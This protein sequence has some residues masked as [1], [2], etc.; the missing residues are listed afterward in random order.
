MVM[1]QGGLYMDWDF[2]FHEAGMDNDDMTDALFPSFRA[3]KHIVLNPP[4]HPPKLKHQPPFPPL[5]ILPPIMAYCKSVLSTYIPAH[6]IAEQEAG[7]CGLEVVAEV[8]DWGSGVGGEGVRG[9]GED[10]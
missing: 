7:R 8:W 2:R 1:E 10:C 3:R 9:G 4:S 6:Q 5:T